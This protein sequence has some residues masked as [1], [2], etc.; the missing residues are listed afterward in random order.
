MRLR[1]CS[2]PGAKYKHH[3]TNTLYLSCSIYNPGERAPAHRHTS[4]ASRFVLHGSGGYTTIEGEKCTMERGDLILT[5]AGTW[6]DHGNEGTEPVMWVDVLDLPLVENLSA[7]VFENDFMEAGVSGKPQRQVYQTVSLPADYSSLIYSGGGLVPTF[8]SHT[9]GRSE[10]SPMLIY[11]W[12]DVRAALNRMR[13]LPGSPYDG[14]ILEYV[15]PVNG[16]AVTTTMGFCV[17]MLRP[18]EAT[19]AH[20]QRSSAAYCCLEGRGK[21]LVGD[22]VL[23]WGPNDMFVIPSWAPHSHVNLSTTEDAI[24][25]SV[26]DIPVM[27]KLG[28]YAE[29]AVE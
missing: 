24:L 22:K 3:S 18:G 19:K 11:R 5:P 7:S 21:T 4:N 16:H 15:N 6:H 14:I 26:T 9:R 27:K 25:Y 28:L 10:G 20:R 8:A 23:A 12:K 2:N 29:E 17:Q 13:D 1:F